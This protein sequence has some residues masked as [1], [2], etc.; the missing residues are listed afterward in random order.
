MG[1]DPHI[2]ILEKLL[3][4]VFAAIILCA[5]SSTVALA[6]GKDLELRHEVVPGYVCAEALVTKDIPKTVG[7]KESSN[8]SVWLCSKNWHPGAPKSEE[9]KPSLVDRK[10]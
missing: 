6:S 4:K 9:A 7:T 10:S 8:R 5:V 2:N 3:V 1:P